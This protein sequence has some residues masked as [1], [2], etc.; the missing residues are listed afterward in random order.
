VLTQPN[1]T[2]TR[3]LYIDGDH[4][5]RHTLTQLIVAERE[6]ALSVQRTKTDSSL[7]STLFVLFIGKLYI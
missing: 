4:V 2:R 7:S 1:Q 3:T 5:F 6:T